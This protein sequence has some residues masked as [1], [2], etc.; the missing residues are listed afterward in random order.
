[1]NK[2]KGRE[3]EEFG[4]GWSKEKL[5][6]YWVQN[7]VINTLGHLELLNE[8]KLSR[9]DA[10]LAETMLKIIKGA[11]EQVDELYKVICEKER[12]SCVKGER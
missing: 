9:R 5:L 1:M 12:S 10:S 7:G 4:Y 8:S 2:Q 6:C 11:V 3:T